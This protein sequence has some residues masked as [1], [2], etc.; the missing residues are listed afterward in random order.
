MSVSRDEENL[1]K[2]I[3]DMREKMRAAHGKSRAGFFD[4]KHD[5]GAIIDIEFLVQFLI[6]LNAN[7]FFK[8]I[9]WT[10]VVRQLNSLALSGIIDDRTAYMLKQ[11]Y[12][13]FRYYV[14]RLTL[15]EKPA[16]LE[17]T[18]FTDLREE[19]RRIWDR[20]L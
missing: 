20:F 7:K 11:A 10:D 9:K 18:K 15:Q 13:V 4:L 5:T 1:R 3:C 14:H 17:D 2:A 8:L 12:L 16:C 6:L 19:I